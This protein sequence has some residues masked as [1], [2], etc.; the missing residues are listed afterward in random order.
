MICFATAQAQKVTEYVFRASNTTYQSEAG[1]I[2]ASFEGTEDEGAFQNLDIGFDFNFNGTIYNTVSA[3]TNGFAQLGSPIDLFQTFYNRNNDLSG[4]G[5]APILAPLWDDL[6]MP[7]NKFTYK[8]IGLPG[9]KVF[10]ME[11]KEVEWDKNANMPVI[12]FQVRLY[13]TSN[14]IEFIYNPLT[15]APYQYCSASIGIRGV[16][17]GTNSFLSLKSATPDPDIF[18][19]FEFDDI[20]INP[21]PGQ[22]YSFEVNDTPRPPRIDNGNTKPLSNVLS[23]AWGNA[24]STDAD[25]VL[26]R[27]EGIN[28]TYADVYSGKK[29]FTNLS[30]NYG[31]E[32]YFRVKHGNSSFSEEIRYTL[33]D[34][35]EYVFESAVESFYLLPNFP[36]PPM[37]SIQNAEGGAWQHIPIGFKFP[38]DGTD[39]TTVSASTHGFVKLGSDIYLGQ[40]NDTNPEVGFGSVLGPM[41]APLWDYLKGGE[42]SY[43][44]SGSGT[45]HV[46]TMQWKNMKWGHNASQPGITILVRLY[47]TSGKIEFVY[48]P[49]AG[50]LN[51]PKA[52]IGIKGFGLTNGYYNFIGLESSARTPRTTSQQQWPITLKPV[53]G[54]V[55][56]FIPSIAPTAPRVTANYGDQGKIFLEW[57]HG[58]GDRSPCVLEQKTGMDGTFQP[59]YSGIWKW[60][61]ITGLVK[62]TQ[63]FF[64]VKRLNSL[65]SEETRVTPMEAA[66]YTFAPSAGTFEPVSPGDGELNFQGEPSKGAWQNIPIGFR[67]PYAG[68][69]YTSF[70]AS[71]NGFVKLGAGLTLAANEYPF[72]N[73]L[74][75]NLI[76]G[77]V[78]APL[79][80]DLSSSE[81]SYS[82]DGVYPG[83]ILTMQWLN[84]EWN[85]SANAGISFQVKLHENT[86]KIE[87]VYRQEPGALQS[88]SASVGIRLLGD[89]YGTPL[90]F[91]ALSD[92]SANPAFSYVTETT[93]IGAKPATGQIYSFTPPN[94]LPEAIDQT[95]ETNEDTDLP[96]TLSG[97]DADANILTYMVTQ[98]PLHGVVTGDPTGSGPHVIYRPNKDYNGPDQFKF[99][100]NDGTGKSQE[101]V[102]DIVVLPVA[103]APFSWDFTIELES[104]TDTYSFSAADFKY[105]DAE[106][107]AFDKIRIVSEETAGDLQY[108]GTSVLAGG[109]YKF[110]AGTLTFK[111]SGTGKPYATFT[112]QV[113]DATGQWS[114]STY[115]V[116][117]NVDHCHDFKS[118]DGTNYYIQKVN[119]WLSGVGPYTDNTLITLYKS[120]IMC[121]LFP[122][123]YKLNVMVNASGSQ[124]SVIAA[125]DFNKDGMFTGSEIVVPSTLIPTNQAV[126]L[127]E[128]KI[129]DPAMTVGKTIMRIVSRQGEFPPNFDFCTLTGFGEVED[130]TVEITKVL[131][132]GLED[133]MEEED[134]NKLAVYPNPATE[135]MHWTVTS[136]AR[137]SAYEIEVKDIT[138]LPLLRAVGEGNEGDIDLRRLRPGAYILNIFIQGTRYTRQILK[139]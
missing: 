66:D 105:Q 75:I 61:E 100:V 106:N 4:A 107:D 69:D 42:F 103:D 62:G 112:F 98:A 74:S 39:I 49:E 71:T 88:P 2:L 26:Q 15:S 12:D 24:G 90:P 111:P 3:S 133:P 46:F 93:S 30:L 19:S 16:G 55:Y 25:Y 38:F 131:I 123:D 72:D 70:T 127:P 29:T 138:G 31:T 44:L 136:E 56:K 18:A 113:Q 119:S 129:C 81:F 8:T 50:A 104:P 114:A 11:W 32:Y 84:V 23:L 85:Q 135:Y 47:E 134:Q 63:Y 48:V 52:A 109:E 7:L 65:Y 17:N 21:L 22:V 124:A 76:R 5:L 108:N 80:D 115:T 122:V 137:A 116:T 43:Q 9:S 82:L 67:F 89:E 120:S 53:M 92:F 132:P 86:G 130:Y 10:V 34:I 73:R 121:G 54:Q 78:L 28:G 94:A 87:Y 14:R 83:R 13:E 35:T 99:V 68:T 79:W 101:A 27:K 95:L 40:E 139:E 58:S 51:A 91:I 20:K 33:M 77:P 96:I 118:L 57:G 128:F 45:S 59:V 97:S 125:I 36:A 110:P 60:F 126:S 37:Q 117:I 64:R 102:V 6:S 41:L 1:A